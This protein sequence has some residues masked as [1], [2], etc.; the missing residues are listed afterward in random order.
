MPDIRS[1]SGQGKAEYTASSKE[2]ARLESVDLM[3]RI[4][5]VEEDNINVLKKLDNM[6]KKLDKMTMDIDDIK[7]SN[8]SR[9]DK[10]RKGKNKI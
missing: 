6:D 5:K 7:H 2:H 10:V 9:V 8:A 3:K 1:G 4:D